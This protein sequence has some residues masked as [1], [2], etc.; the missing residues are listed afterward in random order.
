MVVFYLPGLDFPARLRLWK[1]LR[2]LGS[3]SCGRSSGGVLRQRY[4]IGVPTKRQKLIIF[5][6]PLEPR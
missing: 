4:D 1:D 3:G 6:P 2:K 5:S